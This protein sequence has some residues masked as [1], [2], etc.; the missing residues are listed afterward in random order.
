V[1]QALLR[2][3]FARY[4]N[5][6]PSAVHSA[7][8]LDRVTFYVMGPSRGE[9][10]R[11]DTSEQA[12]KAVED[13]NVTGLYWT[14]LPDFPKS[15]ARQLFLHNN[16]ALQEGKPEVGQH[17]LHP[18]PSLTSMYPDVQGSSTTYTYDPSKPVPTL[19]GNNLFLACGPVDQTDVGRSSN[20]E[21]MEYRPWFACSVC[22][23][24]SCTISRVLL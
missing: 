18:S 11:L 24:H 22:H 16:G 8:D 21:Y 12:S 6:E 13:V 20:H 10:P 3:A 4:L 14:T 23:F 7:K 15:T 9:A 5:I 17:F 19:G 2:N 1:H